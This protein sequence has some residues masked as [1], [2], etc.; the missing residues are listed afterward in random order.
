MFDGKSAR[1]VFDGK[2]KEFGRRLYDRVI[3]DDRIEFLDRAVVAES[4]AEALR[5]VGELIAG[6]LFAECATDRTASEI[7]RFGDPEFAT[8]CGALFAHYAAY[9]FAYKYRFMQMT[10]VAYEPYVN[11]QLA[12]LE[13]SIDKS[14]DDHITFALQSQF[15]LSARCSQLFRLKVA[16][17]QSLKMEWEGIAIKSVTKTLD[18]F[19]PGKGCAGAVL[20]ILTLAAVV[21]GYAVSGSQAIVWPLDFF[22]HVMFD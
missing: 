11:E 13:S 16:L 8:L 3:A 6:P 1:K 19:K 12:K 7:D 2:A 20:G 22:Y 10:R 17:G 9:S 14:V 21:G 4:G 15:D 18:R 5:M